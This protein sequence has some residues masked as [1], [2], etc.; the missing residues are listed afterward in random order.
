MG[1]VLKVTNNKK[2]QESAMKL[3]TLSTSFYI[4][5]KKSTPNVF[6]TVRRYAELHMHD[7]MI[8]CCQIKKQVH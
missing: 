7:D 5:W 4:V 6:F 1:F 2:H 3:I 8:C